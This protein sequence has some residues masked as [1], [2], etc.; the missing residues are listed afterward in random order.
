[1]TL[2]IDSNVYNE[3]RPILARCYELNHL[4]ISVYE[5]VNEM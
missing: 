3:I 1:M 5:T 4:N 2:F